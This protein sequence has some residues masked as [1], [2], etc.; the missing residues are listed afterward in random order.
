MTKVVTVP[1]IF[2]ISFMSI[3]IRFMSE[4]KILFTDIEESLKIFKLFAKETHRIKD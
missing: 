2:I 1:T 4:N 3:K